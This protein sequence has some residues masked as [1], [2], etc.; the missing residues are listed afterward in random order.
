MR[1]RAMITTAV[2]AGAVVLAGTG[3]AFCGCPCRL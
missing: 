3:T 2:L 1:L